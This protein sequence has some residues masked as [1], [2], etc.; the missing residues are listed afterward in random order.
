M[1]TC[2]LD[3]PS[4]GVFSRVTSN[5]RTLHRNT[6]GHWSTI[7]LGHCKT[8]LSGDWCTDDDEDTKRWFA[9]AEQAMAALFRLS[10]APEQDCAQVIKAIHRSTLSD[11][12]SSKCS[13]SSLSRF[14]H[15]LGGCALHLLIYTEAKASEL[16]KVKAREASRDVGHNDGRGNGSLASELGLAAEAELEH[17]QHVGSVI[18]YEIVG[19]NLLSA[20]EP[21]LVRVV[22]NENGKY[23]NAVLR[24]ASV[25]ALCKFMC[26]SLSVCERHLPLLF[27]TLQAEQK[28]SVRGNI[29]V[30]LGDLAFRFPNAVEP[31][32][33][34]IYRRLRDQSSHVRSQTLMVLTHL[35]LNDMIKVKGQVSEIALSLE[36][37][38]P[39]TVYLARLFFQEL[40]KRG[41]NPVYNLMP[42]VVS[43]LSQDS[44]VS[45]ETF[46]NVIPFLMSFIVRD[47]HSESLVEK[48]CFRFATCSTLQQT[49]DIAFCLTQLPINEKA[50]CKLDA[51]MKTYKC[52]LFDDEVYKS[53]QA[54]VTKAKK[55]AKPE[56]REAVEGFSDKIASFN[57][58]LGNETRLL[59]SASGS[60]RDRSLNPDVACEGI[61]FDDRRAEF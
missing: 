57:S 61:S 47:K 24:E 58:G 53:F 9:A 16:K 56:F 54:M 44:D 37:E 2:Y 20:Y 8:I 32:A 22:V 59:S 11:R 30:A 7:A 5:F 55:F 14:F 40:S 52:A 51:L 39:R 27:T 4:P 3:D 25:L 17:D 45:R 18:D 28:P 6:S 35:I 50:L 15:V 49:Q 1:Q 12:E 33:S 48:L 38:E 60:T 41:N 29:V 23:C 31:W 34:H 43:R 36:D 13:P 42:D 26:V 10:A 19:C 21:I 46:R